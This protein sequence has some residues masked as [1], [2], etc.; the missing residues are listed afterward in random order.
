MQYCLP[1]QHE[2]IIIFSILGHTGYKYVVAFSNAPLWSHTSW[3][4][5]YVLILCLEICTNCSMVFTKK[6]SE[7]R[8]LSTLLHPV[9][10]GCAVRR[11]FQTPRVFFKWRQH[12]IWQNFFEPNISYV[13]YLQDK[14]QVT[15][16]LSHVDSNNQ[17]VKI[18]MPEDEKIWR[19]TANEKL[20]T[21]PLDVG[22][23]WMAAR[24]TLKHM[25]S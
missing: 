22:S 13:V 4:G 3:N 11:Q 6:R 14:R 23:V 25:T 16:S 5:V 17:P 2:N 21:I 8:P 19:G 7:N 10:K 18:H 9:I 20:R 1:F 12:S 24:S 15:R